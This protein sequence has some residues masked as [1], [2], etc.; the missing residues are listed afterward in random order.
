VV[1]AVVTDGGTPAQACQ[2]EP[3]FP[4][5]IS[6]SVVPCLSCPWKKVV[7]PAFDLRL[8]VCRASRHQLRALLRRSARVPFRLQ[9]LTAAETCGCRPS[10]W[11]LSLGKQMSLVQP[12][13]PAEERISPLMNSLRHWS[14]KQQLLRRS[15]HQLNQQRSA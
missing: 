7:H 9:G 4:A 15:Q 1:V 8:T 3:G 6:C 12:A 2:V 5:S 10:R 13:F 14:A 11:G